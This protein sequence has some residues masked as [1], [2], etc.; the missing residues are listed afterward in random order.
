MNWKGTLLLILLAVAAVV[1]VTLS[2][3]TR[4]HP[5]NQSLITLDPE[6]IDRIEIREGNR[7]TVLRKVEGI[8]KS[9]EG[10]PDRAD[11]DKVRALLAMIPDLIPLDTLSP[12]E[13]KGAVSLQSLDLKSPKRTLT[14][15]AGSKRR[16]ILFGAEG[17]A[18]GRIYARLEGEAPVHLIPSDITA[19]AFVPPEIFRDGRFTCIRTAE[20]GR[21]SLTRHGDPSSLVLQKDTRGWS[22]VAPEPVAADTGTTERWVE[23]LLN[24]PIERW[25]S[26]GTDPA[27]CGLVE[28]S[29]L[30]TIRDVMENPVLSITLGSEVP[31]SQGTRYATCSD[32]PGICVLKDISRFLEASPATLRSRHPL[33]FQN[34]AVDRIEI[35]YPGQSS[36]EVLF[37]HKGSSDWVGQGEGVRVAEERVD[38]WLTGLK[39]LPVAD[40][41]KTTPESLSS[42]DLPHSSLIRLIS[43]LS[44]N[45]A[46]EKAGDMV[47][48]EFSLGELGGESVTVSQK[49]S[50]DLMIIP[51]KRLRPLMEEC[52]SWFMTSH[53][54]SK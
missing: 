27:A 16:T 22:L 50:S 17:A 51:S 53:P 7:V 3:G 45:S 44:E 19:V 52:R 13:L 15:A 6:S 34:D 10:T 32:R 18:K 2:R 12:K 5:Q 8:W 4:I 31:G 23:S 42:P 14:L 28:P 49:G 33:P 9:G 26:T 24:A 54:V 38:A 39:E 48:A 29:A 46:E 40:F 36:P 43:H 21:F 20:I 37:R 41:Q 30:V 47:L 35:S 11:P 25:M 1:F